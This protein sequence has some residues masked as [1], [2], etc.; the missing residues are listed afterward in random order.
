MALEA[1]RDYQRIMQA[2]AARDPDNAGWQRDLAASHNNVGVVLEAQG[3][4]QA[5]RGEY[6][7]ALRI[8]QRLVALDPTNTQWQADLEDLRQILLEE[9]F[10]RQV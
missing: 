4:A 8:A 3:Q 9:P 10:S 5:A 1:Y 2:L 7:M 6:E